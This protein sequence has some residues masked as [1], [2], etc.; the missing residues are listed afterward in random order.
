MVETNFAEFFLIN[1]PERAFGMLLPLICEEAME[2][3]LVKFKR[4]VL[5][6]YKKNNMTGE[7]QG[8]PIDP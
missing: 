4:P 8:N 7:N 5:S 1:N 2:H 6:V 3:G